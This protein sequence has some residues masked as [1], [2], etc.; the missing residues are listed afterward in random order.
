MRGLV[1]PG[2]GDTTSNQVCMHAY[3]SYNWFPELGLCSQ[4]HY[5]SSN[6]IKDMVSFKPIQN[7]CLVSIEALYL[8][9]SLVNSAA[10]K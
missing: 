3:I 4:A 9:S 2:C 10:R 8:F 7:K 1:L 6:S 5:H